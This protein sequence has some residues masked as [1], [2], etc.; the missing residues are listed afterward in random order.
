M[1]VLWVLEATRVQRCRQWHPVQGPVQ[2]LS[3]VKAQLRKANIE[4]QSRALPEPEQD[5]AEPGE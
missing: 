4:R 5:V 2:G 3:C 1:G